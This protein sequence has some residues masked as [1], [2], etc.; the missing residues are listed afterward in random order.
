MMLSA[1]EKGR[2][3]DSGVVASLSI[4]SIVPG[5]WNAIRPVV[6]VTSSM[7]QPGE[8]FSSIQR[9]NQATTARRFP[10]LGISK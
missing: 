1:Q 5:P 3:S 7:A 6:V 8:N 10:A 4:M 2:I 9:W